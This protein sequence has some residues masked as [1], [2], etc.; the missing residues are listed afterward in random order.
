MISTRGIARLVVGAAT[1]IVGAHTGGL[2][3]ATEFDYLQRVA[4]EAKMRGLTA[5]TTRAGVHDYEFYFGDIP[6]RVRDSSAMVVGG[7]NR[8][9]ATRGPFYVYSWQIVRLE[10]LLTRRDAADSNCRMAAAPPDSALAGADMVALG[11]VGGT[12]VIDGVSVTQVPTRPPAIRLEEARRYLAVGASCTPRAF[13]VHHSSVVEVLGDDSLRAPAGATANPI[14]TFML[15]F[16]T[17]ARFRAHV[18]VERSG[19]FAEEARNDR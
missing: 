7:W 16:G 8:M 15:S 6:K 14:R 17:L 19:S 12:I 3:A 5:V 4:D 2:V 1:V 10:S 11:D 9:V 13:V 18:T